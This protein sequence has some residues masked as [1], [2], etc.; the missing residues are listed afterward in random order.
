MASMSVELEKQQVAFLIELIN[1]PGPAFSIDRD[2]TAV[3]TLDILKD[4]QKA[5]TEKPVS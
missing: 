5:E 3:E 1:A 4:L 2:R